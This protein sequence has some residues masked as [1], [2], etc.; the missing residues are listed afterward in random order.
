[1]SRLAPGA[2]FGG[3]ALAVVGLSKLHASQ[4]G[5][6]DYSGSPRLAW[7]L[8]YIGILAVAAYSLGL[9]DVPRS[10]RSAILTAVAAATAGAV[11]MSLVQLL[12]GDALL[13]T[14]TLGIFLP[15]ERIITD[16][17]CIA[18]TTMLIAMPGLGVYA[19]RAVTS[20]GIWP[21]KEFA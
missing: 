20:D 2:L 21:D 8:A 16:P 7:S 4:L 15:W 11:G 18:A 17:W 6:Y 3:I 14:A 13:L 12:V 19:G 5:T 10:R 1:M 9:P